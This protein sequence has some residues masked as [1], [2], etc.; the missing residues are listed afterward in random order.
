[1]WELGNN[2]KVAYISIAPSS[3]KLET[4]YI[5]T[6]KRMNDIEYFHSMD[7]YTAVRMNEISWI[8]E[9]ILKKILLVGCSG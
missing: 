6:N 3:P 1:M 9:K 8:Y 5:S 2:E 7:Q 4:T